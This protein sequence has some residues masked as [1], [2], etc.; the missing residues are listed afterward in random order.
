M[1][2]VKFQ[3]LFNH[4]A[5]FPKICRLFPSIRKGKYN[6]ESFKIDKFSIS[7]IYDKWRTIL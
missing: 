6:L 2:V 5:F 1:Y 3:T 7:S 4:S